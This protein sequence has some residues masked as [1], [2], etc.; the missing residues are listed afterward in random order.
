MARILIADD[1][2]DYRETFSTGLAQ[3]GHDVVSA[4]T[5]LEAIGLLRQENF[6]VVF[7]DIVMPGGGAVTLVHDISSE[8]PKLPIIV[9]SGQALLYETPLFQE[10]LRKADAVLKKTASLFE[11]N[12]AVNKAISHL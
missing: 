8:F 6:D 11:I 2:A 7:L 5:G 3:L 4:P 12:D 9:I 10:G 1:D